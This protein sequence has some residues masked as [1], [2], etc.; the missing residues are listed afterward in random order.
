MN[1]ISGLDDN[2][3]V[4]KIHIYSENSRAYNPAFDITPNNLITGLI[5]EK[6]IIEANSKAL[7][8]IKYEWNKQKKTNCWS[9]KISSGF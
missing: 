4:K 5:T 9:I 1:K 7:E 3:N 6:G 8:K 2:G